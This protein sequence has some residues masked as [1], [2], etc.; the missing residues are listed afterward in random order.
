[1]YKNVKQYIDKIR[2]KAGT[3]N[4]F[5]ENGAAPFVTEKIDHEYKT[6]KLTDKNDLVAHKSKYLSCLK[7]TIETFLA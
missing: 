5:S 4:P 6:L 7:K 2:L 1:M 3:F